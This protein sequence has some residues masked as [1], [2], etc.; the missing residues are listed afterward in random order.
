LILLRALG[1]VGGVVGFVVIFLFINGGYVYR[2]KCPLPS[3]GTQTSW[4]YGIND[5][6]PYVRST[7]APC[8]SHSGTRLALSAVG[9]WPIHDGFSASSSH[10]TQQDREAADAL[11]NATTA[12][13]AEL[14]RE[15]RLT[16]ELR[17]QARAAGG[18]TPAIQHKLLSLITADVTRFEAIK[19][20]LDNSTQA[21]DPELAE[22]RREVSLYAAREI[23]SNR[24]FL[25]SSSLAKA[26][27]K[28]NAALRKVVPVV[29][30][31]QQ[32]APDIQARY[33]NVKDWSF[34]PNA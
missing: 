8:K 24:A 28:S 27:R 16:N 4:T 33:P 19:T 21:K 14:K 17:D 25:T 6:I 1:V 30:R 26:E 9:V 22:A 3:G 29:H 13:S 11:A 7:S 23:E 12:L 15:Q 18:A 10:V 2:T 34:L 32:L 5:V 31:L 20:D